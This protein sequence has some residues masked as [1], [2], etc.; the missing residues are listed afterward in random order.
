MDIEAIRS[1][2]LKLPAVT[3][4]VKWGNDLVFSVGGRMFCIADMQ[5]P[6]TCSF[7]VKDEE[8]EELCNSG[9]FKPAAY[10]AR[11]RWITVLQPAK[12]TRNDWEAYLRQSYDLVKAKLTKKAQRD[13]GL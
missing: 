6:L 1:F 10:M 12:L 4:D 8:F 9:H 2:C 3:E 7:K 11:A 13:L 5:P